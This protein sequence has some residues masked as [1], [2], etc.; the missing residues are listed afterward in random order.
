MLSIPINIHV[1]AY[2]RHGLPKSA[3]TAM[4]G[5]L[6]LFHPRMHMHKMLALHALLSWHANSVVVSVAT[7]KIYILHKSCE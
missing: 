1:T 7:C 5:E 3:L 6:T 4:V 2:D